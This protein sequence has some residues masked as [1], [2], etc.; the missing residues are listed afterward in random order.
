M[1]PNNIRGVNWLACQH[2][3]ASFHFRRLFYFRVPEI[4]EVGKVATSLSLGIWYHLERVD[5]SKDEQESLK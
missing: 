1:G 2:F 4:H 5:Q 3:I